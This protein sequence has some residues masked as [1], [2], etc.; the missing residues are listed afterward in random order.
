[1]PTE[2]K[3]KSQIALNYSK[4]LGLFSGLM[5]G[6]LTILFGVFVVLNNQMVYFTTVL[7]LAMV[8][9]MMIISLKSFI[10][11]EKK[12]FAECAFGFGAM[13]AIL[14]SIVYYTQIAV[15]LKGTL[16]SDLLLIV[17]DIPGSVF[18]F[19]DMLGYVLLCLSTLF[20]AFAIGGGN[21]L[22]Q[23]FLL[24]HSSLF[25]PTFLLPFLPITFNTQNDVSGSLIL[26]MWCIIFAPV[27]FL[28]A[29]YF[30]KHK[31]KTEI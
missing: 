23:V 15:V 9:V 26:I 29:R 7:F 18:F 3:I 19:L 13:Y 11:P 22:L 24:I 10:A 8:V 20:I 2:N 21:R 31:T 28:L 25:I 14:V 17:S 1:M 12:V 4:S 27:C 5:A 30:A 16:N 6:L